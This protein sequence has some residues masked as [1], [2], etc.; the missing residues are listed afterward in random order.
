[1]SE[2][3]LSLVVG[4]E[5]AS[6]VWEA[7]KNAYA[8]DSQEREFTLRQQVTYFCKHEN[9]S[10]EEHIRTFKSLSDSFAAIGKPVSD[11]EKVFFLLT[12]LGPQYE[13]FTTA[14]LKP[15]RPSYSE[16][17]S[18]LQNFDQRRN[19]FSSH[20]DISNT[21]FPQQLAFYGQQQQCHQQRT[22]QPSS[23]HSTYQ[24]TSSGRGFQAPQSRDQNRRY[25]N[26]T[27]QR[28]PPPPG[29]R[30]MTQTK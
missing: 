8:K 16:L 22:R 28:Q 14:M 29:E 5:T 17:V 7:L 26:P 20:T 18:Q 15:P 13:N 1:L 6:A 12:S 2:E 21:Q 27:Q 25:F 23:A 11:N 9:Q 10:M 3:A 24:F 19:W 4:L 30:R